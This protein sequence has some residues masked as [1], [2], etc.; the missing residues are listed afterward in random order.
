MT[1]AKLGLGA[2]RP[3][4]AIQVGSPGTPQAEVVV[5]LP[6]WSDGTPAGGGGAQHYW[7]CAWLLKAT[8]PRN[9]ERISSDPV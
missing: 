8:T 7:L 1:P 9:A 6:H 3:N 5:K 2:A 4:D